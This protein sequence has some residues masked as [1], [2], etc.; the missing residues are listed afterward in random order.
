MDELR[1][2]IAAILEPVIGGPRGS[3]DDDYRADQA[4]MELADSILAL[5]E[6]QKLRP[7]PYLSMHCKAPVSRTYLPRED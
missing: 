4:A 7:D 5:P 2:K 6:I 3:S 1:A